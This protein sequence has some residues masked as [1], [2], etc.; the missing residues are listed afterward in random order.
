MTTRQRMTIVTMLD[1]R[2]LLKLAIDRI[3]PLHG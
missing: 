2:L 1:K 3:A